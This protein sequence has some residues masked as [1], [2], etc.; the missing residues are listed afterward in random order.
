VSRFFF[1]VPVSVRGT[2]FWN[3]YTK[4]HI[5]L[6]PCA[7]LLLWY[8]RR[9]HVSFPRNAWPVAVFAFLSCAI[10]SLVSTAARYLVPIAPV[11]IILGARWAGD[12]VESRSRAQ[13]R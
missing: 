7:A 5:G 11:W 9:A 12:I 3:V 6:F 13:E 4:S 2:E 1:D 10:Y 8:A